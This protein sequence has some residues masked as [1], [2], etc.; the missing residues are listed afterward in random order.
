MTWLKEGD[1]NSRIFYSTLRMRYINN[2]IYF[3]NTPRGR[4]EDVEG[5]KKEVRI[6]LKTDSKKEIIVDML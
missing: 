3:I 1:L 2:F 5:V 6:F 4:F